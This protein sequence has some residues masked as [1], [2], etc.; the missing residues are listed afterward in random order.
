MKKILV[1]FGGKSYEHDISIMSAKNIYKC[2]DSKVFNI[3][4]AYI[5]K[6]N[7]W[8]EFNGDFDNIDTNKLNHINNIVEYLK[9]YDI[10]FN[11][12]HGATGE[13]GKLQSLFEL[14]DI[15][16]V[17]SNSISSLLC[18]NKDLTKLL[19]K[20]NDINQVKYTI[21][22]SI[23]ETKKTINYPMI[24]KP[25]NGGSSIGISIVHNDKEFKK[26]VKEAQKFSN[27]IIIEQFIENCLELECSVVK[28]KNKVY[29][30]S[31]GQIIHTNEFYDY[32]DKYIKKQSQ[33]VIP[34]NI[35]KNVSNTIRKT[36]KKAFNILECDDLARVDF[37]VDSNNNIY[38]NEINTLPGFTN[39]SMF[40]K[41]LQY[42]NFNTQKLL[43]RI[44]KNIID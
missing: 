38:L 18:M 9:K 23:S 6:N 24:I 21:Y 5:S 40:S 13:D 27:K 14:F 28:E 10:V 11:I 32:E 15:K 20:E 37:L 1:L 41:L 26:G 7:S 42:D 3:G 39:I 43:T 44:I 8:Y 22:K 2:L 25:S 31:V 30:S 4:L 29:V 19:L 33:L 16:Y 12:I 17:G 34:A 35:N 36:A